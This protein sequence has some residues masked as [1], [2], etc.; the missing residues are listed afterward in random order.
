MLD[1]D[2][3]M[4]EDEETEDEEEEEEN[5]LHEGLEE[6]TICTGDEHPIKKPRQTRYLVCSVFILYCSII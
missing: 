3:S 5:N 4:S 2:A 1:E 6:N